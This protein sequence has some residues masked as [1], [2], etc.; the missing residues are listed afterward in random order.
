VTIAVPAPYAVLGHDLMR[1][2]GFA[3]GLFDA[4]WRA[5]YCISHRVA[6]RFQKAPLFVAGEAGHVHQPIGGQGMDAGIQDGFDLG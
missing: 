1:L 5:R 3:G 6:D 2:S 4:F